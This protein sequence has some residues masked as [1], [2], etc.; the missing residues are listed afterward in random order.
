MSDNVRHRAVDD[1]RV[2]FRQIALD[3]PGHS[4]AEALVLMGS[5]P[6]AIEELQVAQSAGDGNFYEQS[7][8]DARLKELRAEHARELQEQKK[9]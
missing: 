2:E 5:L 3:P 1:I 4:Q 9:R 7:A 6:A 8:V